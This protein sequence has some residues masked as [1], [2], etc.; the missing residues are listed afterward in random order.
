MIPKEIFL[1]KLHQIKA[2]LE[3]WNYE[4]L[5]GKGL[6]KTT[7]KYAHLEIEIRK[8]RDENS[9]IIWSVTD[10]Q[11][12]SKYYDYKP[13][14]EESIQFFVGH[15]NSLKVERTELTFEIK[16]G[17]YHPV[18][19]NDRLYSYATINAIINCF[20]KEIAKFDESWVEH[21]KKLVNKIE[22]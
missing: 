9:L 8:R 6:Y 18:D 10:E 1:E 7:V 22:K 20:D 4:S 11:I 16:N 2:K 12:P 17:S 19:T 14:I 13:Y 15:L 21:I 5:Y 3:D